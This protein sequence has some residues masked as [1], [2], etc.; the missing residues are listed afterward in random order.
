MI[1][2]VDTVLRC[3]PKKPVHLG[4]LNSWERLAGVQATLEMASVRMCC[5]GLHSTTWALIAKGAEVVWE[6]AEDAVYW[7]V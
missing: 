2:A 3:G 7:S 1:L 6:V 4:T 5:P